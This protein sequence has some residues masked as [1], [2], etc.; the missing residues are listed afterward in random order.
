MDNFLRCEVEIADDENVSKEIEQ[1]AFGLV[2]KFERLQVLSKKDLNDNSNNI[3]NLKN[4]NTNSKQYI[5]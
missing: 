4:P 2:K 3:K 1:M 5:V